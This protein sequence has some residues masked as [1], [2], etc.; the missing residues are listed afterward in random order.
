MFPKVLKKSSNRVYFIFTPTHQSFFTQI[1]LP[2]LRHFPCVLA[3]QSPDL[4]KGV[5]ISF[6]SSTFEF[7]KTQKSEDQLPQVLLCHHHSPTATKFLRCDWSTCLVL[8][9]WE[10]LV[11]THDSWP[12]L[13]PDRQTS[14][15][16]NQFSYCLA[17]LSLKKKKQFYLQQLQER[18][19]VHMLPQDIVVTSPID[20]IY[21]QSGHH[22][23]THIES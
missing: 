14:G 1:Y 11:G 7:E 8:H 6:H 3:K 13:W 18:P 21:S 19:Q 12:I 10:V 5:E 15:G 17:V 4:W 9:Q 22:S 16:P 2:C 20:V 23:P